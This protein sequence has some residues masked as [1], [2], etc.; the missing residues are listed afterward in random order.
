MRA[1]RWIRAGLCGLF[2]LCFALARSAALELEARDIGGLQTLTLGWGLTG[3]DGADMLEREQSQERPSAFVLWGQQEGALAENRGLNRTAICTQ[4]TLWGSS[5]LLLGS[6]APLA[7]DDQAGC[8]LDRGTAMAL[9][10]D[11]APVGSVLTLSGREMTV[12][13]VVETDQ[14]L[15]AVLARAGDGGLDRVTLRTPEGDHPRLAAEGFAARNGLS[16]SWSRPDGWVWLARAMSL[17]P[18]AVL[19]LSVIIRCISAA[20]SPRAGRVRFWCGIALAGALWFILLWLTEFR[21]Q[22]PEEMIPNKW[23]DFDFWGRLFQEKREELVRGLSAGR[24][25]PEL[26]VVLPALRAAGFGL[27]AAAAAPFMPRPARPAG[28]WVCCAAGALMA[29]AAALWLD[30]ALA[31]DRALWLALPA[32]FGARWAAGAVREST[33]HGRSLRYAGRQEEQAGPHRPVP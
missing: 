8:L 3:Q 10:G 7:E 19:L 1:G 12:R 30:P 22:L 29:F 2:F 24:T 21:F 26:A 31:H 32:A 20:F 15:V 11:P 18:V 9:F 13:G 4:I 6:T 27:L 25:A 28:L 33:G 17:L 5:Q 23:S 14:P 16:G